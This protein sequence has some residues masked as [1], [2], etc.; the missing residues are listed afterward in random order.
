PELID[1]HFESPHNRSMS[2]ARD[3]ESHQVPRPRRFS[4]F[5]F[6]PDEQLGRDIK[7]LFSSEPHVRQIGQRGLF[8][9][10]DEIYPP[11]TRGARGT[12]PGSKGF[13]PELSAVGRMLRDRG[14][15]HRE[16][17]KRLQIVKMPDEVPGVSFKFDVILDEMTARALI[18]VAEL[19]PDRSIGVHLDIRRQDLAARSEYLEACRRLYQELLDDDSRLGVDA[20][21]LLDRHM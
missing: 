13:S 17:A 4:Q 12:T 7:E 2:E 5:R 3:H 16:L 8:L 6:T 21:E 20:I 14:V 19:N 15:K 18:G 9:Y 10:S 1:E 11:T